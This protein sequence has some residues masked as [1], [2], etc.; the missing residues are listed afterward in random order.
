MVN[1]EKSFLERAYELFCGDSYRYQEPHIDFWRGEIRRPEYS[2]RS[3]AGFRIKYRM[4]LHIHRVNDADFTAARMLEE[5]NIASLVHEF[6]EDFLRWMKET[7]RH[8]YFANLYGTGHVIHLTD[9]GTIEDEINCAGTTKTHKE[10]GFL[11]NGCRVEL[12]LLDTW[13]GE[14]DETLLEENFCMI[15]AATKEPLEEQYRSRKVQEAW[16]MI[17]LR[18]WLKLQKTWKENFSLGSNRKYTGKWIEVQTESQGNEVVLRWTYRGN[19][20]SA[21]FH[22]RGFRKEGGFS[23]AEDDA[24]QGTLIVD[25]WGPDWKSERLEMGKTYFYTFKVS[26]LHKKTG[27]EAAQEQLRFEITTPSETLLT[28]LEQRMTEA[29][30]RMKDAQSSTPDPKR[31]RLNR[32]FEELSEFVEFDESLTRWEKDLITQI[33]SKNYS[34]EERAEKI[35]RLKLAVEDL[36]LRHS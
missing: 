23:L 32:A 27:D 11:K 19:A 6:N 36:R 2:G 5:K 28:E 3:L 35:E 31:E 20:E 16:T 4:S 15:D 17:L 29:V 21:Q 1:R 24:S 14:N 9:A 22:L 30:E 10:R 33:G 8:F 34:D 18:Q 25:R 26:F 13:V 7:N 12:V